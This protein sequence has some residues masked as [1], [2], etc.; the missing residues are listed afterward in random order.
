MKDRAW[1][2]VLC[3]IV[4]LALSQ[5]LFLLLVWLL[6]IPAS[7]VQTANDFGGIMGAVFTAGGLIVAIISVYA[8][9]NVEATSRRAVQ[10]LLDNVPRE[11]DLRIRRFGEAYG[12]YLAAQA[13]VPERGYNTVDYSRLYDA[14]AEI[15][16]AM[17]IERNIAGM[18]AWIGSAYH[19][20][21]GFLYARQHLLGGYFNEQSQYLPPHAQIS[22]ITAA[23]IH[24]LEDAY[25]RDDGDVR[26]VAGALAELYGILGAPASTVVTWIQRA[27]KDN[28]VLPSGPMSLLFLFGACHNDDDVSCIAEA[29]GIGLLN[30]QRVHE[31]LQEHLQRHGPAANALSFLAILRPRTGLGQDAPPTPGLINL[32]HLNNGHDAHVSWYPKI[33]SGMVEQVGILPNRHV[34]P[35]NQLVMQPIDRALEQLLESFYVITD[36]QNEMFPER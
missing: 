9:I 33:Q 11:I 4:A 26:E 12:H 29:L 30:A 2:L 6:H 32:Y 17:K 20:A 13:L 24:W 3:G 22:A 16:Q 21:A 35:N 25:R 27:N 34:A 14:Q 36:W 8:L 18:R 1:L 7:A 15:G 31:R 28:P 5:P 19:H 10:P 23:G